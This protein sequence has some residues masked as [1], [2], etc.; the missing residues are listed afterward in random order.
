VFCSDQQRIL[1][2]NAVKNKGRI[3]AALC[4]I[5]V[6]AP[7]FSFLYFFFVAFFFFAGAFF[8]LFLLM[9]FCFGLTTY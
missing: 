7:S 6:F 9:V 4:K 5:S 2:E 8:I 3:S 1:A